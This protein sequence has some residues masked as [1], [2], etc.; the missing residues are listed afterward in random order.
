MRV[1]FVYIGNR[2]WLISSPFKLSP[3]SEEDVVLVS[4]FSFT[5]FVSSKQSSLVEAAGMSRPTLTSSRLDIHEV[6]IW[7]KTLFPH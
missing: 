6:A 3:P 1:V 5:V 2:S 7:G 4:S